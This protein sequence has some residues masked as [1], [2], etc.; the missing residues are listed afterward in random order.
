[1]CG[2]RSEERA[3]TEKFMQL[4][5]L[6]CGAFGDATV[7]ASAWF[8]NTTCTVLYCSPTQ[9]FAWLF[10]R[11]K[12]ALARRISDLVLRWTRWVN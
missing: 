1:M 6:A 3:Q 2:P 4:L 8:P 7:D 5:N 9:S 12:G 10:S 11:R